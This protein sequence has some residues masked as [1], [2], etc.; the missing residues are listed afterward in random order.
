MDDG[1]LGLEMHNDRAALRVGF[2][3]SRV[4]IKGLVLN[5]E[6]APKQDLES[7]HRVCKH[8]FCEAF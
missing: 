8:R 5:P 7:V 1:A 2:A 6:S 3:V 4:R